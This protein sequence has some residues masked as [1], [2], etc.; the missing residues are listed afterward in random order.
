MTMH[1]IY[2]GNGN[3]SLLKFHLYDQLVLDILD[4]TSL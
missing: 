2:N 4:I 3:I 1:S